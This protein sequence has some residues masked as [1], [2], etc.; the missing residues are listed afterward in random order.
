MARTERF[1]P[2]P[3]AVVW[4]VLADHRSYD[5]WVVGSK[6]IRGVEGAWPEPGSRFHH[7]VGFGPV[8]VKDHT[9]SLEAVPERRLKLRA[10]ARPLGTAH[11]TLELEPVGNGTRVTMIEDAGDPLTALVFNPLTH[12]VV[13]GRNE[14]SL[15]RLG[16]L[17]MARDGGSRRAAA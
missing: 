13:R 10:K 6:D 1:V 7:S 16:E 15:R 12:L 8:T 11:V 9:A 3:A 17:A 14:E 4:E 5:Y 2:V